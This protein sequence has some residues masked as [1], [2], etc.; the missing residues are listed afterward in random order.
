MNQTFS[1]PRFLLLVK[2]EFA[3]KGRIQVLRAG[4]LLAFLLMLMLP[5]VFSDVSKGSTTEF[6]AFALLMVVLFGGSLYTNMAFSQYGPREKGMAALMVPASV[7]EKFLAPL[8]L[9][10]LVIVPLMALFLWLHHWTIDYANA[11]I[12]ATDQQYRK[13]PQD[14]LQVIVL[15]YIVIQGVFFLGSLYFE[16]SQYVK[17]VTSFILVIIVLVVANKLIVN[18]LLSDTSPWSLSA[19]PFFGWDLIYKMP[20]YKSFHVGYTDGTENVVYPLLTVLFLSLW[21]IT[22]VRLKEKEI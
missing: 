10:L 14:L 1:F 12:S 20:M 4:L 21:Y 7:L 19:V 15:F 6:H 11:K 16:K 8:V 5:I 22:Y 3:E 13:I 18:S 2:A 9:N 17:T